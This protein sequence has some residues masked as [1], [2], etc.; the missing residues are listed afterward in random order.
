MLVPRAA[1]ARIACVFSIIA[2]AC[3]SPEDPTLF[4]VYDEAEATAPP[5]KD[6]VPASTERSVFFGDLHIHTSLSLDAYNFGVRALPEDAYRFAKGGTIEHAVGYPIQLREPL[7]FAAVTDHAEYLGMLRELEPESA[8][9]PEKF[10]E[11]LLSR[12]RLSQTT[13]WIQTL[14]SL[15]RPKDAGRGD[16]VIMR[17]AWQTIIDAAEQ[18]NDPGRFTA[19]VAYE[20]SSFVGDSNLH[21]NVIYRSNAAPGL[22][23]SANDSQDPEDLWQALAEQ[24][25][26]GMAAIAIPHNMN[27]SDG[28]MYETTTFDGGPLDADYVARRTRWEPIQEIFQ[29]KGASETHPLLSSEDEFAAFEIHDT[30]MS[31]TGDQS[32]PEGSYIRD[33]LRT[34]LELH[35]AKGFDPFDFGVIGSSDGHNASAPVEEDRYHGKLPLIDGSAALRLGEATWLPEKANQALRYGSGGLAAIWAEENTRPSLFDAMRRRET[36]ATSGTRITLRM[37]GGWDFPLDLTERADGVALADAAGVPMGGK[38]PSATDDGRPT[39]AVWALKDPGGANLDRIQ[40]VKLWV[41]ASGQ[42][43]ER[44]Y[45]AAASDGRQP[46]PVTHRVQALAST[47]DVKNA[48][49]MNSVGTNE[50]SVVWR[51]PYF[52]PAHATRYYA[53]VLEIATPRWS[54]Y[55]A[56]ALGVPAPEPAEIKERAVS[57]AISYLPS[58]ARTPLD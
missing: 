20:W 58:S 34:G 36:Y 53:R 3:E 30:V 35:V 9:T 7:D 10:R 14:R 12:S 25:E 57:S 23:F 24:N 16:P 55:D 51:D 31:A 49:Y 44:I 37:F 40:I 41:D 18:A 19:F 13:L 42:S 43:F 21:R 1:R 56:K 54:T 28:R 52:D 48:R 47:V 4:P 33:A 50:L 15:V 29:V 45:D 26:R 17:N 38:L 39:L 8:L 22:P 46:D 11:T 2:L 27:L 6:T 32:Q 5:A